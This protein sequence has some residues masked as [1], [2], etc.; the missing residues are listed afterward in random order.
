MLHIH[1]S[2]EALLS[3]HNGKLGIAG[4]VCRLEASDPSHSAKSAAFCATPAAM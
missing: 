4:G 3:Y 2:E 1:L